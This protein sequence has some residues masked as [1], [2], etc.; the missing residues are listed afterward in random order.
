ML[1]MYV[2]VSSSHEKWGVEFVGACFDRDACIKHLAS[3]Y[4]RYF[5]FYDTGFFP[6]DVF[7]CVAQIRHVIKRY[8]GDDGLFGVGY[9]I[10][11][12]Q[13]AAQP[14][15]QQQIIGRG[16]CKCEKCSGGCNF[17][18]CDGVIAVDLIYACENIYKVS[19]RYGGRSFF[20]GQADALMK[21]S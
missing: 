3:T 18:K 21:M 15:L 2:P 7:Y 13:S 9:D 20:V 10:G 19:F 12:V 6:G 5:W 1:F 4:A 14:C 16:L 11:C 17:E 8:R